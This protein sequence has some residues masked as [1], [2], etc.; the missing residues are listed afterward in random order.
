MKKIRTLKDPWTVTSLSDAAGQLLFSDEEYIV[1]TKELIFSERKRVT[2]ALRAIDGLKVY[3]PVANFVLCRIT[4]ENVDA[5][6]L[7][8]KAIRK[9]MMIRNCSTFPYL[10]NKYFRICFMSH[11]DNDRLLELIR[12]VMS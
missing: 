12:E 10:D 6:I 2:E 4:K 3:E 7:F 1:A 8:D 11:K 5:D 9:N